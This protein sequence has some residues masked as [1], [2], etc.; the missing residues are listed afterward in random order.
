LDHGWTTA[1]LPEALFRD[2]NFS[3]GGKSEA[4]SAGRAAQPELDERPAD[5]LRD[6]LPN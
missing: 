6:V 3:K 4:S 1:T 2:G 5:E